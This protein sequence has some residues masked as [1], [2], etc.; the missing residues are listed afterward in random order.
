MALF[1]CSS[2]GGSSVDAIVDTYKPTS[3]SENKIIAV[4][5]M[6]KSIYL[7]NTALNSSALSF[8]QWGVEASSKYFYQYNGGTGGT[9]TVGTRSTSAY[10]RYAAAVMNVTSSQV[11]ITFP[12][13]N[14]YY[15]C[16]WEYVITF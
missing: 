3:A 5:K 12:E 13:N 15:N 16:D 8:C 14:S 7:R 9:Q 10:S 11:S 6:P 4:S 2:G 1:R